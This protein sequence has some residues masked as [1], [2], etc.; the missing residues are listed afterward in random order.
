[1]KQYQVVGGNLK[2]R[3]MPNPGSGVLKLIPNGAS[4]HALEDEINGWIYAE[5]DGTVGYCMAR[6]LKPMSDMVY[7]DDNIGAAIETAF[8]NVQSALDELKALITSAL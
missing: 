4:V 8:A 3:R 2:L 1:M 6:F 5:Y 7:D